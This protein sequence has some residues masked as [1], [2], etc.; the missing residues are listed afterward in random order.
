MLFRSILVNK[1]VASDTYLQFPIAST[2]LFPFPILIKDFAG[3]AS[4]HNI[5]VS[6]SGGEKCDNQST[7][8]VDNN[9]GWVTVNPNPGGGGWYQS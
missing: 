3:N 7:V 6:F 1:S 5:N 2:M 4:S 8:L 9:Y